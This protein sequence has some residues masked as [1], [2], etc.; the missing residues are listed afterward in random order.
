MPTKLTT[1]R[2]SKSG[3]SCGGIASVRDTVVSELEV[4][5]RVTVF[6]SQHI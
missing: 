5:R 1:M 6:V 2:G 3:T 4:A